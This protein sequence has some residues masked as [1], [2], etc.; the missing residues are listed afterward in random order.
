MTHGCVLV[1]KFA[2]LQNYLYINA[3]TLSLITELGAITGLS[4][5]G[6]VIGLSKFGYKCD[7]IY[8]GLDKQFFQRIIVNIFL[9][10]SFNI[11]FWCF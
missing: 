6:I 3:L 9:P 5:G 10:I 1:C 7:N 4:M 8:T 11:C 2:K